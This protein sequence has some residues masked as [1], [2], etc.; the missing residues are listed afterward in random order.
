M[1]AVFDI[2]LDS[3]DFVVE[4]VL[5]GVQTLE[6]CFREGGE[7]PATF[8]GLSFGWKTLLNGTVVASEVFPPNKSISYVATYEDVTE[9]CTLLFEPLTTYTLRVWADNDGRRIEA[10]QTFETGP[11]LDYEDLFNIEGQ[12]EPLED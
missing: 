8:A 6:V 2:S 3:V 5:S 12:I 1:R 7:L 4:P 11:P 9:F 10:E